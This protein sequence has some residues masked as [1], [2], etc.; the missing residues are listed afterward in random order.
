[1]R[2]LLLHPHIIVVFDDAELT[3]CSQTVLLPQPSGNPEEPLR[4]SPF[5]KHAI[6]FT[7]A[8]GAFVADAVSG[9]CTSLIVAQGIDWQMNPNTVNHANTLNILL[10]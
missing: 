8:Y 6:L 5:K 3:N 2:R 1:M 10:L 7:L 9:S 4:W